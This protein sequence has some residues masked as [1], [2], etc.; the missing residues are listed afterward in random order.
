M[1]PV[2]AEAHRD[3]PVVYVR[4]TA[5]PRHHALAAETRAAAERHGDMRVETFYETADGGA[6]PGRI[7]MDWLRAN[8]HLAE[9]DIHLCG[10][11][12]FLRHFVQGLHEAGVPADRI[13]YE[14][15]GPADEP[16]AA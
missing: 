15:F 3:V 7:R 9:A 8:T 5:S 2:I 16:L 12:P 10:P 11:R 6:H 4:G 1:V 14:F 13:H